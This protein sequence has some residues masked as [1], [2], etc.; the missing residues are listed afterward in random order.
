MNSKVAKWIELTITKLEDLEDSLRTQPEN[1]DE[2]ENTKEKRSEQRWQ[3]LTSIQM[4]FQKMRTEQM[5]WY[6]QFKRKKRKEVAE[7]ADFQKMKNAF[8]LKELT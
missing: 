4:E 1:E 8:R 3:V 6:K 2:M 5:G 7:A